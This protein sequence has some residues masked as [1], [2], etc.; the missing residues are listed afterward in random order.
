MPTYSVSGLVLTTDFPLPEL[1]EAT[2]A[3][4]PGWTVAIVD[5]HELVEPIEVLEEQHT[6]HGDLWSRRSATA[7]GSYVVHYPGLADFQIRPS[8]RSI[9]LLQSPDLAENTRRHLLVDQVVPYLATLDGDIVLH[10]SAISIGGRGIAFV[11]PSGAGKSSLAAAFVQA[12]A[13]VLCDD[14][15]LLRRR[16]DAYEATAAYPGLRLWGDSADHFAGDAEE[17]PLVAHFSDKRRLPL[18]EA[19]QRPVPLIAIIALGRRPGDDEPICQLGPLPG[20]EAFMRVFQQAFR[21]ERTG[22]ERQQ[23]DLDRFARLT[24]QVPVLGLE[25]RRSY[26]VL[27]EVLRTVREHL[28]RLPTPAT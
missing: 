12:G 28:D 13:S 11:G 1:R 5:H 3:D 22:R 10:S 18:G 23:A 25:H 20:V 27:P 17:L 6:R 8:T 19:D 21:L 16:G 15:L 24:E 26:D 14:Y 7:D 4:A 9:G 2:A